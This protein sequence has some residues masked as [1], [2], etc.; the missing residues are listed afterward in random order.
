MQFR[1]QPLRTAQ[2]AGVLLCKAGGR[3]NRTKLLGLLH[4]AD[5]QSLLETGMPI[6]GGSV[7]N[8]KNGP[9]PSTVL[10]YIDGKAPQSESWNA[11]FRTDECDVMLT[12]QEPGDS[13]LSDYDVELLEKVHHKYRFHDVSR[14][15]DVAHELPEWKDPSPALGEG[16]NHDTIL[17]AQGASSQTI[18]MYEDLNA[19]MKQLDALRVIRT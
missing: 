6:T 7:V 13:E 4:L 1:F 8:L 2:A 17:R 5:R 19:T 3:L 15:I 9:V 16:V 11:C 18:R 10:D 14:M 12:G